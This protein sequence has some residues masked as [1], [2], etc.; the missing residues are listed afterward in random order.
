MDF[1]KSPWYGCT[2][3]DINWINRVKMQ[4]AAQKHVCHA[5]SSTIN[6]PNDVL[7]ETV[8]EIYK[9]AFKAGCKGITIYRD[10]CR[11][12]VLVNKTESKHHNIIK[13]TSPK[14]EEL[15]EGELHFFVVDGV[16]YYA[17]V[18]LLN[19]EPFE[20]FTGK[21]TTKKE[22]YIPK[23]E[24]FGVIKKITRG[25]YVFISESLEEYDL[26]NGHSDNTASAL[27]RIISASLRH[28][29]DLR[30]LIEQLLKTE[31]SMTSFSKVLARTLK[32]YIKDGTQS[33]EE[34]SE[35]KTKMIF[36]NGCSL[37]PSCGNSRCH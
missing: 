36:Q 4:A 25:K 34:C 29:C 33:T 3:N 28:G 6:L 11:S 5:I 14:R 23:N 18:G 32:R 24:H 7:E 16:K 1:K 26:T 19:K 21:N 13:T 15:L 12:G 22:V 35:C 20:I 37:C 2:A 30:F 31:G 10:G 8:S 17:A 9:T 27:S